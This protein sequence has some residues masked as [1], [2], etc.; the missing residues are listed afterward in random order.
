[1]EQNMN[2]QFDKAIE[3]AMNSYTEAP[4]FGMWNRISAELGEAA[5]AATSPAAVSSIFTKGSIYGFIS[6][7]LFISGLVT[8]SFLFNNSKSLEAVNS[9]VEKVV[10][11]A[12]AVTNALP[13]KIEVATAELPVASVV[14]GGTSRK[15]KSMT[16][17]PAKESVLELPLAEPTI[18]A[19]LIQEPVASEEIE[20]L[21]EESSASESNEA[22]ISSAISLLNHSTI[23][24]DTRTEEKSGKVSVTKE[25]KLKF[26]PHKRPSHSYPRINR[27]KSKNR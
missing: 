9:G 20:I 7:A 1:M 22:A 15:T 11:P 16:F 21:A 17:K 23:Y 24:S 10:S 14:K 2:N 6:G 27:S 5:P 19:V 26:R 13:S 25:Q 18:S 3:Q 4:P 8:A 12:E